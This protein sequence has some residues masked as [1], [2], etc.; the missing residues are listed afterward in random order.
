[1]FGAA[2]M[3]LSDRLDEIPPSGIRKLFDLAGNYPDMISLG[4][5]EPD[6]DTPAHIKE[7]AK[8][9]LDHGFTHYTPNNGLQLLREAVALKLKRDNSI[10][11]DPGKNIMITV[12][13][14]QAF[15]LALSTFLK[16]ADEVLLPS[17]HFV[18]HSAAVRLAG[19][20]PVEV[21]STGA[22]GFKAALELMRDAVTS[23]TRGIIINSP[24]NPTGVVLGR[25]DLEGIAEIAMDHDLKVMS[26]EVYE[27]LI[28][29]GEKHV[30]IA[31]LEGMEEKVITINSFSKVYAM[32][33]WRVGYV[34]AE[35]N[36][37]AKMAK[38]Q[39]YAAACPTSFA[40]YAAAKAMSDPRSPG[41]VEAMR[42]EYEKRRDCIHRRIGQIPGMLAVKP[43]GAFYIFPKLDVEDDAAISERLL[44]EAHVAAVPGSSFGKAGRG[45]LRFA[46]TVPVVKIEE[47][48][49]RI[50]KVMASAGKTR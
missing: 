43:K 46:Y 9:A 33:G 17:P 5:G 30:S 24:N 3:S 18:T 8:E 35:E 23:K 12:G 26:D 7:Y 11:A 10:V 31:S 16:Q 37:I 28:Y 2:V 32:T 21:P 49:D 40:Q 13:G 19:G 29:D 22:G 50:E 27:S 39:M 41:T 6:F 4:I 34:V 38:F 25:K 15:L 48:M 14:N 36:A 42:S 47:A 44:K 20:V 1:M 45:H